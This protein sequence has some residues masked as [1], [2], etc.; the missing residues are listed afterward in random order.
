LVGYLLYLIIGKIADINGFFNLKK[1]FT[2]RLYYLLLA[3]ALAYGLLYF[4]GKGDLVER[5]FPPL[6]GQ[7]TLFTGEKQDTN[8]PSITDN[9]SFLFSGDY[10]YEGSGEV[11]NNLPATATGTQQISGT[12]TGT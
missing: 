8:I 11:I 4:Y 5:Y 2:A 10:I 12:T 3:I 1:L 7:G 9:N 6:R